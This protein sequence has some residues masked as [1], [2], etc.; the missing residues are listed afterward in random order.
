VKLPEPRQIGKLL[1]VLLAAL[2]AMAGNSLLAAEGEPGSPAAPA[3]SCPQPAIAQMMPKA[4]DRSDAPMVIY[5]RSLDASKQ[6]QGV[7][8]GAVE[9]FRADQHFQSEQVF[10]DP[11]AEIVTVPGALQYEDQQIWFMGEDGHYDFQQES[12]NFSKINYGLT[13]SSANGS[14]DKVE[15]SGGESSRLFGLLYSTCPGDSPVWLL[16]ASELKLDHAKG[17]GEARHAKLE[18]YGVPILYA[19]WFTF[20]IDDRRKSG[21]LYPNLSNT[22][23]NGV[24]IGVPWYW[25]IAPNHDAIIE[26]RYFTGRG[27]MLTG[28]YRLLTKRTRGQLEFDYMHD[29]RDYPDSRHHYKLEHFAQPWRKWSTRLLVDRV[30]DDNYFQDF[31]NSIYQTSLQFLYSTATVTG[32]GRYWRLEMLADTFQV[33]DESVLAQNEPYKRLPRLLLQADKPFGSSGFGTS[34]DS[35]LVYFERDVGLT[36]ARFDLLPSVYWEHR[37]SWGF[38]K[39]RAAYRYTAYGL[40]NMGQ[41]IDESPSRSVGIF[42]LDSGLVFDRSNA[43]G[44]TQTLEPR[45]Y[46]LYVPY[47]NQD[48]LPLFDSG[49]MTFGFSQL[50]N[51]NRFAGA[52]R[53]GDANQVALAVSSR[54]YDPSSGDMRWS[55]NAGQIFY[56]QSLRLQLEGRPEFSEDLS[57]FIAEFNWYASRRISTR[58]GVQWDWELSQVDVTSFGVSYSGDHGLRASFDYRFR[59]DRVDQFDLRAD[60]PVNERWRLMSQVNYS[61]EDSEVLELQGGFEYESCCWALRTVMRR[62]LK[63]RE[64]DYRNGIYLELNLKGLAS[65]G[66]RARDLFVN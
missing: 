19:P 34:L 33:I 44:S 17:W 2:L 48:D 1:A 66:T 64:G 51:T 14:A 16:T 38:I 21:F 46:Y 55:I 29:D 31:G 40:D 13:G 27:L 54:N 15:L 63:N 22:N 57:P 61:F 28:E 30:S 8:E 9:L 24:E 60:W 47:E 45:L 26:P 18:F 50:F 32:A 23:D 25:N 6:H 35:E 52:D 43:D 53:Q 59:R 39:P 4:P 56:L 65:V 10:F 41:P 37:S 49:E 58:A 62:Y 3:L 20:P 12:G 5:A 11:A 7:A 42:S 36:G